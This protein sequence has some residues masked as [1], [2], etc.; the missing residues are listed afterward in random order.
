MLGKSSNYSLGKFIL[1]KK[2]INKKKKYKHKPYIK[3]M[4]EQTFLCTSIVSLEWHGIKGRYEREDR[5][6]A[7]G[8]NIELGPCCCAVNKTG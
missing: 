2:S 8:P 4:D 7:D 1:K 3:N 6:R 5:G